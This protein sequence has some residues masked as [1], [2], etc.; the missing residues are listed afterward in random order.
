MSA[1]SGTSNAVLCLWMCE[2]LTHANKQFS[3][4]YLSGNHD[5]YLCL[6]LR[7]DL[8]SSPTATER[9]AHFLPANLIMY[10]TASFRKPSERGCN[11][12][13]VI[14]LDVKSI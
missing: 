11:D 10:T 13:P 12:L 7:R 1:G 14:E 4:V 5:P 6:S 2:E 3:F 9:M 8:L